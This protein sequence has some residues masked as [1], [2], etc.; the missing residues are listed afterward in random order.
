MSVAPSHWNPVSGF[1]LWKS[2]FQTASLC[3]SVCELAFDRQFDCCGVYASR[4]VKQKLQERS[5]YGSIWMM[6]NLDMPRLQN[7]FQ[8]SRLRITNSLV[9]YS[10]AIKKPEFASDSEAEHFLNSQ[11]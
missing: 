3:P 6:A 9:K 1:Q 5:N 2:R 8:E 11:H 4:N 7:S 10:E